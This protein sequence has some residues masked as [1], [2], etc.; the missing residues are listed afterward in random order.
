M[1]TDAI[2]R[3]V[4]P[5]LVAK[6]IAILMGA[7][8][9]VFL[10]LLLVQILGT[11]IGKNPAPDWM[12]LILSVI[13]LGTTWLVYNLRELTIS[14]NKSS[15]IVS[16]GRISYSI[17]F[18]NIETAT[19]D[20]SPGIAYGG[21]G[22]RMAKIKGESALIYNVIAQPRVILNLKSGRFKRFAFSTKQPDE[23]I[24]LI[25]P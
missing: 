11:P 23:V 25:H 9:I 8:S 5:F 4:I 10:V 16:Y 7:L 22:I 24:K 1:E 19:I 13:F 15:V 12:Y 18:D 20:T 3:E 2:Y 21:W 14:I 6:V 17:A